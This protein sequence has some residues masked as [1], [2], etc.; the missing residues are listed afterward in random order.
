MTARTTTT[1]KLNGTTKINP[2][3]PDQIKTTS[4]KAKAKSISV[5]AAPRPS[6]LTRFMLSEQGKKLSRPIS[7][8]EK[9]MCVSGALTGVACAVVGPVVG[10]LAA[11]AATAADSQST[12]HNWQGVGA[13][14]AGAIAAV[15]AGA[16]AIAGAAI[17]TATTGLAML[18]N[19]IR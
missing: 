11:V 10:T 1:T 19:R 2:S 5:T 16:S 17:S 4:T 6:L 8:E 14:G 9:Q 15:G 12:R 13:V 3:K 7:T 18:L